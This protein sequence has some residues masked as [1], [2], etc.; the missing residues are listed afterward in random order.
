MTSVDGVDMQGSIGMFALIGFALVGCDV[1]N[2]TG[3]PV[4][5]FGVVLRDAAADVRQ[6]PQDVL[7][8]APIL[9]SAMHQDA[10][11]STMD[12]S[13]TLM[14]A[15]V[16]THPDAG[17]NLPVDAMV[18]D[19]ALA[20][21]AA[22]VEDAAGSLDAGLI[23]DAASPVDAA[24]IVDVNRPA[25]AA[26]I[27]PDSDILDA[28]AG[29]GDG[30]V[31]GG[32]MEMSIC[33]AATHFVGEFAEWCGKVDVHRPQGGVWVIDGDCNTGCGQAPLA[34]C[35]KFWPEAGHAIEVEV[36]PENKPFTTARCIEEHLRPG[37][38]QF[39]CCAPNE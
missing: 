21:D 35:R 10:R 11:P 6:M 8:P 19:D 12:M 36:S 7:E 30:M 1:E 31:D 37:H 32:A 3:T 27:T 14:D 39:V 34:Y 28:D 22:R 33:P 23:R 24:P 5:D 17:S 16:P 4:I 20:G 38:T 2:T 25:D 9:D 26:L 15:F 13:G 18:A 29:H